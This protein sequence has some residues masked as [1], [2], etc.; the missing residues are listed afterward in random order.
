MKNLTVFCAAL[1]LAS[2]GH[3]AT[4]R[5][6]GILSLAGDAISTVTYVPDIG[7][8]LNPNDVQTYPMLANTSFDETAIRTASAAIKKLE[9]DATPFLMLSTDAELHQT[10]NAI[11]DSPAANQGNRDYLKSLW[12]DK[13]ITHLI[14]VTK[15]R[16]DAELRFMQ[17]SE[18]T[19]K[20]EGLGFYMDNRARV[21]S[22][23]KDGNHSS[24]G[25]L[26]PYVYVKLRL[27]NAETLEPEREVRQKQSQL[28]TYAPDADRAVRTWDALT[29]KQKI[30]YLDELL[31]EAVNEAVPKLL[32]Q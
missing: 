14:L 26:M 15:Y 7:T 1:L 12:K 21:T 5:K 9:P 2:T 19:G 22:F 25:V 24:D 16:A 11:F 6:Y 17:Q 29:A 13:G 4:P 32:K 10:Q 30:V 20:I 28:V 3:T 31:Q 23:G 18:G 8:K 27:V